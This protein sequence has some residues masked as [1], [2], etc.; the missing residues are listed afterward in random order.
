MLNEIHGYNFRIHS[1]LNDLNTPTSSISSSVA[2]ISTHLHLV[3]TGDG[4]QRL[5]PVEPCLITCRGPLFPLVAAHIDLQHIPQLRG[6]A[7]GG[8]A[9]DLVALPNTLFHLCM[10]KRARIVRR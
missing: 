6:V 4:W 3:A 8:G 10:K 7:H 5:C 1:V 9:E 2:A